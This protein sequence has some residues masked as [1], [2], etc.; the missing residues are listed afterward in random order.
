MCQRVWVLGSQLGPTSQKKSLSLCDF[1]L[2]RFLQKFSHVAILLGNG[3]Q[4][5]FDK[6]SYPQNSIST[7]NLNNLWT[8]SRTKQFFL[9]LL[10]VLK[11]NL[12]RQFSFRMG[13][14]IINTKPPDTH[15]T[16]PHNLLYRNEKNKSP[17]SLIFLYVHQLYNTRVR[18]KG[19]FISWS[20]V[21]K[22]I[23]SDTCRWVIP[24]K[25]SISI[26]QTCLI[27]NWSAD[28]GKG[29]TVCGEIRN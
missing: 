15:T 1:D 20:T 10:R 7:L 6:Q 21:L 18:H 3:L 23:E 25:E 29:C 4:W 2:F 22:V 26:S 13:A 16:Q 8:T 19:L 14:F 12:N 17:P 5:C 27:E 9:L 28:S 24:R 11:Y